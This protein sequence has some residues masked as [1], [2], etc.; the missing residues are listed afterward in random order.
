MLQAGLPAEQAI[1][2]FTES[3]DPG[4]I[5]LILSKWQRS[6]AV[7]RAQITLMGK[8]WQEMDLETQI[9]TSLDR[10]YASLAYM[11]YSVNY[12]SA[13]A[14]EKAKLDSARTALEQKIAGTSGKTNALDAFYDDLRSGKIKLPVRA[15]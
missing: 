9:K 15:N 3:Q 11:L 12:L 4:E 5:A 1:L 2:Y 14:A 7:A 10:H 8:S 6:R 13:G